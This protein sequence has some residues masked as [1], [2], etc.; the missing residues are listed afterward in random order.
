[1]KERFSKRL[2]LNLSPRTFE[3]LRKEADKENRKTG[4][5]ARDILEKWAMNR[6][7]QK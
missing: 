5:K 7:V 6:E 4:N 2:N 1:M 3:I